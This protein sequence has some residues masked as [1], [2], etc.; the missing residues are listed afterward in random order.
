[1]AVGRSA[2]VRGSSASISSLSLA[3]ADYLYI[4]KRVCSPESKPAN[5][6]PWE[7]ACI[8]STVQVDEVNVT[9]EHS[10]EPLLQVKTLYRVE[11]SRRKDGE[12]DVTLRMGHTA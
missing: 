6:L 3:N 9:P 11:S 1:M 8:R 12:V 10:C 5:K 7:I 2:A 4:S